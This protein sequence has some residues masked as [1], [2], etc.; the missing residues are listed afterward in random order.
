MVKVGDKVWV[1]IL[2]K[3]KFRG[4][5]MEIENNVA[6]INVP[7]HYSDQEYVTIYKDIEFLTC[8]PETLKELEKQKE[9]AK[10]NGC[11]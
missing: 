3:Y 9:E 8:V 7:V 6:T 1:K 10:R 4:T 2:N 5:I 11:N